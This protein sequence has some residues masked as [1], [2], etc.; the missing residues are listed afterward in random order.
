M[1]VEERGEA[2]LNTVTLY[3]LT[4]SSLI[5]QLHEKTRRFENEFCDCFVR[6]G[7]HC[8]SGSS[9]RPNRCD[10][11]VLFFVQWWLVWL[12]LAWLL[13]PRHRLK[14]TK[15]TN[16]YWHSHANLSEVKPRF[17]DGHL[18]TKSSNGY[19]NSSSWS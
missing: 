13:M 11:A 17:F 12:S 15:W 9:R 19:G 8:S 16:V 14:R 7:T 18:R 4:F 6:E 5:L 10:G 2:Q 1:R 3:N